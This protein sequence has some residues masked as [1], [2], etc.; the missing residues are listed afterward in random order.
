MNFKSWMI[1]LAIAIATCNAVDL[2]L[3][4]NVPQRKYD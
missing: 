3:P 2:K 4:S 1:S